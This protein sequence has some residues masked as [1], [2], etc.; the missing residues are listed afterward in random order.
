M[1]KKEL[2]LIPLE[3]SPC[4]PKNSEIQIRC[5]TCKKRDVCGIK[6]DYL[7]TATLIQNVLGYPADPLELVRI[8]GFIGTVVENS[9]SYFPKEITANK[10]KKGEFFGAKYESE[11]VIN[12][13]YKFDCY[14]V[15]YKATYNSET[16]LLIPSS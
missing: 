7:K 3:C 13:I 15:L 1:Y 4:P 11:I 12:F 5:F 14:F 9:N 16:I 2:M 8:K 10:D 6:I